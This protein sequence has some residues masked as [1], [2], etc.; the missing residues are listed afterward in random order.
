MS[1]YHPVTFRSRAGWEAARFL[2]A[3]GTFGMR[4]G[5]P[6]LPREV[7]DAAE[8][9]VPEGGGLAVSR[10]NHPGRFF[11]LIFDDA[12]RSVAFVKVSRDTMGARALRAEREAVERFAGYLP[13]PMLAPKVLRHSEGVLVFEAVE[14]RARAFPWRLPEDVAFAIGVFTRTASKSAD[15]SGVAHGDFAPWNLLLT[16]AGWG[17]VDWEGLRTNAPPFFDIFHYLVQST[18]E[19]RRPFVRT[20]VE[21]LRGRGWIGDAIGAYAAG[22]EVDPSESGRYLR[23]YLRISLAELGVDAPRRNTRVRSGLLEILGG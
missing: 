13:P 7:W 12:G 18:S 14:W 6:L 11:S 15:G 19:L 3:R 16:E 23:E 22:A 4:R 2:A 8:P 20:I 17:V 10:G 21:G 9:L 1:V 5:S